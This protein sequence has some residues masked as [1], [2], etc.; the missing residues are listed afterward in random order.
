MVDV[1]T[2]L[3]VEQPIEVGQMM[4][5]DVVTQ[6]PVPQVQEVAREI[7]RTQLQVVEKIVEQPVVIRE[8]K[9]VE[10]PEIQ[11][12]EALTQVLVPQTEYKDKPV[13][14]IVETQ[15]VEKH[16]PV[17]LT[18]MEERIVE[19][20]Q[21]QI[22]EALR[23]EHQPVIKEVIKHVPKVQMNYVE[24][25]VEVQS[26]LQQE[27]IPGSVSSRA[28]GA[29]VGMVAPF[30]Q[31]FGTATVFQEGFQP[32]PRTPISTAVIPTVSPTSTAVTPTAMGHGMPVFPGAV[33][34]ID[35][36]GDG[37]SNF[38]VAG[39][40]LNRDGIPDIMQPELFGQ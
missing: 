23:E 5:V 20:P 16:V 7:L 30:Q 34:G 15:V 4:A 29:F 40:D 12:V 24:K 32:V 36:T 39:T 19:V 21:Q 17:P 13:R 38:L 1:P 22:V 28:D 6:V 33:V 2:V 31:S 35:T 3:Q 10:V 27:T 9:I 18:L 37:R 14:K 11:I 8:E 26:T 25:V